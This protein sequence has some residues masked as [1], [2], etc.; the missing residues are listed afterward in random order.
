VHFLVMAR[1]PVNHIA[2]LLRREKHVKEAV[3]VCCPI[4]EPVGKTNI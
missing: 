1:M 3:V 4:H 2:P